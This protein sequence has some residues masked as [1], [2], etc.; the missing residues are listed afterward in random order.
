VLLERNK[1]RTVAEDLLAQDR[2]VT[3]GRQG[4][5]AKVLRVFSDDIEGLRADGAC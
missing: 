5:N 3:A 4:G 2:G 1:L